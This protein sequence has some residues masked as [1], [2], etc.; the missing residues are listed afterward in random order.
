MKAKVTFSLYLEP[1]TEQEIHKLVSSLKK[2]SPGYDNLSA[3]ILQLSLPQICPLLTHIC[4]LSLLE[5]IFPQEM[6]LANV[7]PLFKSGDHELFNNYRPVS[8]LCTLSKVFEKI[9]YSRLINYL[10]HYKILFSYQFGFRVAHSTYMA[11]MVLIDKLTTALDDGKF[12]VGIQDC[13]D[14]KCGV[15]QWSI[16][17]PVLFL[18]YINDLVNVCSHCLPILF[19]DDTNLFVSGADLSYISEILSKA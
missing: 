1:A 8:I 12:V 5:G 11:F 7:I 4:N 18:I 2:S 9:M 15:P 19:A 10:D 17:G 14:C 3:A 16:L 6:K 13:Q